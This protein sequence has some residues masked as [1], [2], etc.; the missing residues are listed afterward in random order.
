ME[1]FREEYSVS[2]KTEKVQRK[3][4]NDYIINRSYWGKGRTCEQMNRAMNNSICFSLFKREEQ[5]GFARV[6]TDYALIFYLADVFVLEEHRRKGLGRWLIECVL[7]YPPIKNIKGMLNTKDAH[8][9]YEKYGF[10]ILD[11]PRSTMIRRP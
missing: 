9:L 10:K 11:D 1:W 5:I 6:I 2:D 8:S 7:D 3:V 4:V